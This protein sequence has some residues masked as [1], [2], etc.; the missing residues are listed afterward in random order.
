MDGEGGLEVVAVVAVQ[1]ADQADVVH[2]AADV[3]EQV[4]DLGA[5][6]P[7]R[8]EL[9]AGPQQGAV[10]AALAAVGDEARL[11]VEG[12]QVRD[13]AGHVE[14]DDALRL[15]R[16]VRRFRGERVGGA[17]AAGVLGEQVREDGRHR[18]RAADE[19]ADEVAARGVES[20]HDS[21]GRAACGLAGGG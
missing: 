3:R 15:A 6:L 17:V 2:A 8:L 13:A 11:G 9:P 19:G 21:S 1:R 18:Q 10:A 7:A 12:V 16:E 20:C 5:A 4:A 14:E